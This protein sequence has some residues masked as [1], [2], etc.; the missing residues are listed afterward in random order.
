MKITID[1]DSNVI[2]IDNKNGLSLEISSEE[3][4]GL[5]YNSEDKII[6]TKG[7]DGTLGTGGTSNIPGNGINGIVGQ[8]VNIIRCNKTVS[9]K[10]DLKCDNFTYINTHRVIENILSQ[11]NK[12]DGD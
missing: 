4:N 3:D 12:G 2:S 7:P 8:G 1:Y 10:V 11:M 5:S 6:A 9:T